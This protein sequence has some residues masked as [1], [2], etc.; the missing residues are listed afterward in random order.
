MIGQAAVGGF[1]DASLWELGR[2]VQAHPTVSEVVGE[3]AEAALRP[4]LRL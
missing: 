1:M 3:A 4:K 2:V